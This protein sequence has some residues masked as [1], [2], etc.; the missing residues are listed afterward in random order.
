MLDEGKRFDVSY[1][2]WST[3]GMMHKNAP[4]N[5]EGTPADS[6]REFLNRTVQIT[7]QN[8]MCRY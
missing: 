6:V 7:I 1:T 4:V 2:L 3:Y 5:D 8:D